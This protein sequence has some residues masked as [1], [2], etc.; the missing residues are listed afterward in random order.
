M[1]VDIH[2][3]THTH[4]HAHAHTHTHTP[5]HTHTQSPI[6]LRKSKSRLLLYTEEVSQW[7]LEHLSKKT[8]TFLVGL[9]YLY[10]FTFESFLH[11]EVKNK[12]SISSHHAASAGVSTVV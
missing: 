8:K 12:G 9:L 10:S 4:A 11:L 1:C 2:T 3:H 7:N 6:H 5:T